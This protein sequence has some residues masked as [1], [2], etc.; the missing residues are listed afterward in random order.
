MLHDGSIIHEQ[1]IVTT[2]STA[3][4]SSSK[5]DNELQVHPFSSERAVFRSMNIID[6]YEPSGV[7]PESRD[8]LQSLKTDTRIIFNN[9]L[10]NGVPPD[11]L[12]KFICKYYMLLAQI[13]KLYIWIIL[14]YFIPVKN[15]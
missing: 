14:V 1:N 10:H 2:Q 5:V 8:H 15:P 4:S 11:V 13:L 6:S 12:R 9:I 3:L 7:R